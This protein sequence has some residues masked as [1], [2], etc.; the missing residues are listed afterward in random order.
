MG[1]DS[2]ID[3]DLQEIYLKYCDAGLMPYSYDQFV[4]IVM[5]MSDKPQPSTVLY[6][7][8]DLRTKRQRVV[9]WWYYFKMSISDRLAMI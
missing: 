3:D 6:F 9:D 1:T 5:E 8:I 4:H 7:G 2:T